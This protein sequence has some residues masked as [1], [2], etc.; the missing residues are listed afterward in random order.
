MKSPL[1]SVVVPAYNAAAYLDKCVQSVLSQTFADFE[2]LLV[3]DGSHDETLSI[4]ERYAK[5]DGRVHVLH[6]ENGGHTAARNAG[7]LAT[8]GKY[9][10]FLDSDDWLGE[11][12]LMLCY[13]E[14]QQNSPDVIVFPV[15][16]SLTGQA[17]T[18][19]LGNGHYRLDG[20]DEAAVINNLLM[21]R[22][23]RSVFTK[24]L[25]GKVFLR[26]VI[27]ENQL[28]VPREVL[29]AE[30]A[31]AFVGAMLDA[32]SVSVILEAAYY[33][34]VREGSVSRSADSKAFD[35]LPPLFAFYQKKLQGSRADLWAQYDRYT[36][37]RLYTAALFVMRSGGDRKA[38]N[39]G[40]SAVLADK[41]VLRSLKRARFSL[42][43]YR[44]LMKKTI[45]RYRLW[46]LAK[47]MDR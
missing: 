44:Y 30:D 25:S 24:A 10:L 37:A 34:L 18:L 19:Y 16:N 5:D 4:C 35:R 17:F 2:L 6:Q 11:D 12:V 42:R 33:C 32:S 41:A 9:V 3:D 1:F 38:L 15:V 13:R 14:I 21:N 31:M 45:L 40:L 29:V 7:L 23:G 36:V 8:V 47:R 22:D 20:A 43:G 28:S 39:R 27:L 26:E 46:W